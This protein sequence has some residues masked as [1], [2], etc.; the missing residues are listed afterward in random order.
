MMHHPPPWKAPPPMMHPTCSLWCMAMAAAKYIDLWGQISG[1]FCFR[2][3][4]GGHHLRRF[5]SDQHCVVDAV[6]ELQLHVCLTLLP[7]YLLKRARTCDVNSILRS[8]QF[9]YVSFSLFV[10]TREENVHVCVWIRCR[11]REALITF[12][13]KIQ[14]CT[15]YISFNSSHGSKLGWCAHSAGLCELHWKFDFVSACEF[16]WHSFFLTSIPRTRCIDVSW[17]LSGENSVYFCRRKLNT[18]CSHLLEVI[19]RGTVSSSKVTL[20]PTEGMQNVKS[21]ACKNKS[22]FIFETSKILANVCFWACLNI[23]RVCKSCGSALA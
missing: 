4:C 21:V 1:F 7:F 6:P 10:G 14:F 11:L 8:S 3:V 17:R 23:R 9:S 19:W 2:A 13:T 12:S 5:C 20:S 18:H 16:I 15:C 22:V